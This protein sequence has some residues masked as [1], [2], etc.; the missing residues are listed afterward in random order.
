MSLSALFFD[1]T[2]ETRE[3]ERPS[4][5]SGK[6]EGPGDMAKE[7]PEGKHGAQ[8]LRTVPNT[9]DSKDVYTLDMGLTLP[10]C[11]GYSQ[12]PAP[13]CDSGGC[14]HVARPTTSTSG[15]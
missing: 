15:V 6:A 7:V 3:W 2:P 8:G 10:L 11:S 9:T 4:P 13:L 5:E 14:S 1:G 12:P